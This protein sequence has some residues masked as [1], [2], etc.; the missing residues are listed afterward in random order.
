MRGCAGRALPAGPVAAV[1]TAVRVGVCVR[2]SAGADAEGDAVLGPNAPYKLQSVTESQTCPR[3]ARQ[4]SAAG[5]PG[6]GGVSRRAGGAVVPS[7]L[8]PSAHGSICMSARIHGTR[9]PPPAPGMRPTRPHPVVLWGRV[10]HSSLGCSRE[11]GPQHAYPGR[12]VWLARGPGACSVAELQCCSCFWNL[13]G[14]C[15]HV[16]PT[17][18]QVNTGWTRTKAAPGTPSKSTATSQPEGPRASS[19]TRSPRG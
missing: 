15:P 7:A 8:T 12:P 6:G 18:V 11:S 9:G 2:V 4:P 5:G 17:L 19:P 16:P 10:T 13:P 14:R 1:A 3:S